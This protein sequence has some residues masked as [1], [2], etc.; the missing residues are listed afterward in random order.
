MKTSLLVKV[1]GCDPDGT[2]MNSSDTLVYNA[3]GICFIPG[4]SQV[5]TAV[6]ETKDTVNRPYLWFEPASGVTPAVIDE[7]TKCP[8]SN[9]GYWGYTADPAVSGRFMLHF[10]VPTTEDTT[11]GWDFTDDDVPPKLLIKVRIRRP[12]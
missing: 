7:V 5:D 4:G 1:T 11:W 12:A 10:S 2:T 9:T 3:F 6:I 8:E